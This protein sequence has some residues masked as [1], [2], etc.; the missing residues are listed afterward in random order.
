MKTILE[1]IGNEHHNEH[2]KHA[3]V[4]DKQLDRIYR[5]LVQYNNTIMSC[6]IC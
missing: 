4:W 3:S 5:K 2:F 6:I 1:N